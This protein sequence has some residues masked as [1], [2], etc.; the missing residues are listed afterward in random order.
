MK[1]TPIFLAVFALGIAAGAV[2]MDIGR[3]TAPRQDTTRQT[4]VPAATDHSPADRRTT[5]RVGLVAHDAKKAVLLEWVKKNARILADQELFSTGT[6]G[7]LVTETLAEALPGEN[8]RVTRFNSGPLGGDQQMGALI[9]QGGLDILVFFVDPLSAH[10][11]DADVKALLR[12]SAVHN[13]VLAITPSTADFVI[14]SPHFA[15][16]YAAEKPDHS[17]YVNRQVK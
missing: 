16:A 13:T 11:H 3:Q 7:R 10:P 5:K 8:V 6:T 4:A 9:A 12:L 17:S 2:V 14:A 15:E 1:K